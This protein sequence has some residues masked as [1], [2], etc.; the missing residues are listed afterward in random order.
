MTDRQTAIYHAR[1]SNDLRLM[2]GR[3]ID[4]QTGRY[5][6]SDGYWHDA[7]GWKIRLELNAN[8]TDYK[9]ADAI[10]P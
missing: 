9:V 8:L 6:R 1:R 4:D 3:T 7:N 2:V 10:A 5:D